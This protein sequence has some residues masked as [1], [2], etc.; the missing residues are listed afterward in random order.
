MID[1]LFNQLNF[2]LILN[3]YKKYLKIYL[4][5]KGDYPYDVKIIFGVKRYNNNCN[6]FFK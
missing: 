2:Y 5:V 6:K 1:Y 3:I 4:I